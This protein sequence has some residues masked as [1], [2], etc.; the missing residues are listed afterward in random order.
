MWADSHDFFADDY[1][2]QPW[3]RC[4]QTDQNFCGEFVKMSRIEYGVRNA[5]SPIADEIL[6]YNAKVRIKFPPPLTQSFGRG[7]ES[8]GRKRASYRDSGNLSLNRI[9]FNQNSPSANPR[10]AFRSH[11]TVKTRKN[12]DESSDSDGMFSF[13]SEELRQQN[14]LI[15]LAKQN[16]ME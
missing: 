8:F 14:A 2:P 3:Y 5:T 16:S 7:R 6:N 15:E 11:A 1:V 12:D 9:S 4:E 13:T 10:D